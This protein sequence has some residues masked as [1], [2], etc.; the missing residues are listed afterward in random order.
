LNVLPTIEVAVGPSRPEVEVG[1]PALA[2]A[3]APLGGQHDE[4]EGRDRLHLP[5]HPAPPPGLVG[6]SGG[7]DH[8]A[9]VPRGDGA[10]EELRCLGGVLGE[11]RR[12]PPWA[13]R[14]VERGETLDEG[15][16]E[17]V[18]T[19]DMET[20][21]EPGRERCRLRARTR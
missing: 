3:V 14:L 18:V 13:R 6:R 7:L 11:D 10:V 17:Q 21:E 15:P 8:D 5:P 16:L 20:V 1:E 2:T 19:V 4:V 9:L 12:N